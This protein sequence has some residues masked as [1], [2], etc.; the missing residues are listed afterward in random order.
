[1]RRQ[2]VES[3]HERGLLPSRV[4]G[5]ENDA[6]PWNEG[7][8]LARLSNLFVV[9]SR[10]D[11]DVVDA[12]GFERPERAREKRLAGHAQERLGLAHARRATTGQQDANDPHGRIM[13]PAMP[14]HR[15]TCHVS[16]RDVLSEPV[17]AQPRYRVLDR[18]TTAMT[19]N[20]VL[21]TL[22]ECPFLIFFVPARL[23]RLRGP[24]VASPEDEDWEPEDDENEEDEDDEDDEDEDEE[25]EWYVGPSSGSAA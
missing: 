14:E 11:D 18:R 10:N 5:I 23:A 4:I 20:R 6:R 2:R 25:P 24:Q 17:E 15:P 1:M 7:K 22:V 13:A 3:R 9:K 21:L 16:R 8:V 12:R 19:T